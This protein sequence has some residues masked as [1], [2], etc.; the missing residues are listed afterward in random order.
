MA[1]TGQVAE[2]VGATV[3]KGLAER[4]KVAIEYVSS[5][6]ANHEGFKKTRLIEVR[7]IKPNGEIEAYCHLRKDVRM[8]RL[9]RITKA[10][11]TDE[12]YAIPQDIQHSLFAGL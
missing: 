6:D 10:E 12:P 5:Q 9:G 4:K 7:Q 1:W 11:L 2:P 8:F 3:A